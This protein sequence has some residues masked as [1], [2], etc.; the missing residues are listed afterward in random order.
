LTA[1]FDYTTT[2]PGISLNLN[3]LGATGSVPYVFQVE[4]TPDTA[5]NYSVTA[6]N[7]VISVAGDDILFAMTSAQTLVLALFEG[8]T[9]SA[10][11]V[12]I[13]PAGVSL[14]PSNVQVFTATDMGACPRGGF[15]FG[16]L[17][18]GAGGTVTSTG[19][20]TTSYMAPASVAGGAD[21]LMAIDVTGEA[22]AT[23]TI[24]ME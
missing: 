11:S 24:R 2:A 10:P 22:I 16:V 5:Y 1:S 9:A 15:S 23:I 17:S 18:G 3:S 7:G 8:T 19:R 20:C 14:L 13:S 4:V 6:Q 21:S 12:A